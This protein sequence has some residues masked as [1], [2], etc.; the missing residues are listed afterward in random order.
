MS[1]ETHIPVL[2]LGEEYHSLDTVELESAAGS[3]VYTHTANPGLIRRDIL[4]LEKSKAALEAVPAE[5]LADYCEAAAELFLHEELPVGNSTQ[6]PQQYIESLSALTKLPHTLVKM[7]MGKVHAA[8]SQ[9]RT[10]IGGLTRNLPLELF[11]RG[12]SA[13]DD[14]E[15]NF[16]PVADALGVS[17]PSNAPAVNSLWLPAP[18]LK[19]PVLLK[20]GREDPFTPLRIVQSLIAAGFPKEAFGFYPTTHE[21]GDTIL[22]GCGR[23]IAFGS[24]ATVRKYS[25]FPSI[26]VHG[27][28]RSKVLIGDDYLGKWADHTET[29]VES[30]SANGGRSCINTSA[31]LV[32]SGRDELA[33]AVARD[34]AAIEPL[35]RDHEEALLCGFSNT[36]WAGSINDLIDEHLKVEGAEDVTARYRNGSRLVEMHGQTYLRPTLISCADPGHPLA[37]TEFMFPFASVTEMPQSQMLEEIGETLVVSAW[38]EDAG[39]IRDLMNSSDIER[40]NIG[41][42]PTNRVQWEQ[43]HE[44]N[45]FEFLFR[46]RAIQGNLAAVS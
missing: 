2:R 16:Y 21:G 23:G 10:V 30:I 8:M 19:I 29:L 44:G 39:W 5:T 17:L 15:V 37:N 14:L 25:G 34:L 22:M 20:P 35:P 32:P 43:P 38:T 11:D 3:A 33:D 45:L 31:I 7:N 27:T 1:K 42:F 36:E 4:N 12:L 26:Q 6:S 24:D 40:L 9:I 18:V 13:V 41:P 28:G 46:R